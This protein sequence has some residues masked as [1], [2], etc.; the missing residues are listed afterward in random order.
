MITT[1]NVN[2]FAGQR[3]WREIQGDFETQNIIWGNIK[4]YYFDYITE[5]LKSVDDV[6]I[7]HE[8]PFVKEKAYIYNDR[9]N[10]KRD[11]ILIKKCEEKHMCFSFL[12]LYKFC[13]ENDFQVF[14]PSITET[15]LSITMAIV[16]KNQ[17][18]PVDSVVFSE[19]KNKVVAIED[20]NQIIIGLHAPM[21][22]EYWKDVINTYEKLKKQNKLILII[23]DF[24]LFV[25]GTPQKRKFFELLSK[26][27]FDLWIETGHSHLGYTYRDKNK[28][29]EARLDYCLVSDNGFN[30]FE[31]KKDDN[32]RTLNYTDHSALIVSRK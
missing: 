6:I 31:I 28:E 3:N 2:H 18:I 16:R 14:I 21:D 9:I 32:I 1:I 23:G 8:V 11:V 12:E 30:C 13:K 15:S 25:P 20:P 26:G 17:Y 4:D 24:N 29:T 19:Y 7:M 27:L 10:Y 22:E 5:H